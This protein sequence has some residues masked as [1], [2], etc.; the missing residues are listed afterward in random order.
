MKS[1]TQSEIQIWESLKLKN[2][3]ILRVLVNDNART[4]PKEIEEQVNS[5]WNQVCLKNPN[6]KDNSVRG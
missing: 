3:P 1:K 2:H 4:L 6:A 5:N